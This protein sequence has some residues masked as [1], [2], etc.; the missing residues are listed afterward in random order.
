MKQADKKVSKDIKDIKDLNER[1]TQLS[2]MDIH[3]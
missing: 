2:L 3:K 1:M